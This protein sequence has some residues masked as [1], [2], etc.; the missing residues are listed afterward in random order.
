MGTEDYLVPNATFHTNDQWMGA[1][2]IVKYKMTQ[3]SAIAARGEYFHDPANMVI[4]TYV[5][6]IGVQTAAYS[7]GYD[8]QLMDN[9]LWRVEGKGYAAA[10]PYF[11][12][13]NALFN[14]NYVLTTSL[15]VRFNNRKN[16]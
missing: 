12:R 7:L 13:G 9:L 1:A 3:R 11:M 16:H 4:P 6:V 14:D 15:A 5:P 2:L 10:T 8:L